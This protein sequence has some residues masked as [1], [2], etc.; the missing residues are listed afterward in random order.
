M[1]SV[2]IN[3]K[4]D[5]AFKMIFGQ[6]AHTPLLISFL[7]AMLYDGKP[8]IASA[9]IINPYLPRTVKTLKDT[10]VDVQAVLADGSIVLI[11][12]QTSHTRAF[13]KRVLYNT[14]KR[15]S[16]HLPQGAPYTDLVS[17]VSLIVAD[18]VYHEDHPRPLSTFKLQETEHHFLYPAAEDFQIAIVELP[19]F[20]KALNTVDTLADKWLFF[21]QN[22]KELE[23]VPPMLQKTKE[24]STA[25]DVA[26]RIN[27]D[28]LE[29]AEIDR[30]ERDAATAL[31]ELELTF[32][33][34]VVVGREEGMSIGREEGMSIGREESRQQKEDMV[35]QMLRLQIPL[36]QI[37][38]IAQLS[39]TDIQQIARNQ[40]N[41]RDDS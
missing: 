34:G 10:Y 24:I 21:M 15:Y 33:E 35:R 14:A 29:L 30:R 13:F 17:V 20:D 19:K 37:A 26:R 23:E 2:F 28:A 11:E 6:E 7:N 39:I 41:G 22:A 18:F 32:E 16:E 36:A 3:P 31:R 12:M 8:V 5:Y 27:F 25:F 40:P 9:T 4:I 1:P 38:Q